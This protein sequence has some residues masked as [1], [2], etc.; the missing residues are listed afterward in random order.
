MYHIEPSAGKKGAD[1]GVLMDDKNFNK[2]LSPSKESKKVFIDRKKRENIA[3][4]LA[5][6]HLTVKQ[7]AENKFYK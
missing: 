2:K 1:E 3:H 7:K 6:I 5:N 4:L